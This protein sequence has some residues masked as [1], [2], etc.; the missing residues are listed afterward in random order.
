M[1]TVIKMP[2]VGQDIEFAKII[3]WHVHEGDEIQEGDILATVESDK[4]SFEVEASESGFV[5][6]LLF[7]EGDEAAVLKPIAYIGKKNETVLDEKEKILS[8]V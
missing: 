8:P 2:Q 1:P 3:E 5:L 4:A 7:K 6:Q